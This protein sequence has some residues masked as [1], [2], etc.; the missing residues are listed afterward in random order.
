MNRRHFLKKSL[1]AGAGLAT[2]PS[3]LT[4]YA[5]AAQVRRPAPSSRINLAFI[6]FGTI[7]HLTGPNFLGNPHVQV[8]AI[9]DPITELPNFGYSGELRGGRLVGQRFVNEHY[10]TAQASG[11]FNGCR[12]YEDFREML[13]KED[14]DAVVISTPDHWHCPI[15]LLAAGMGKHIYGQKPLSLTVEEGRR[16]VRAVQES[17]ITW[18]TGSQQRSMG[19]F[20]IACEYVRNGRLG[21]LQRIEVGM[22]GGHYDFSQLADLTKPEA[23]PKEVNFDLWL[24]PAPEREYVPALLQLNWRHNFDFSGGNITDWGAHHMDIVQWALGMDEGGPVAI[25]NI[26]ATTPPPSALYNTTTDF[27]FDVVYANG[28]RA[29][30]TNDRRNGILFEGEGGKSI[31]VS[32]EELTMNPESLRKDKIR[33]DEIHLYESRQHEKNFIDHIFDGK[34]TAAPI[35]AGHRSISIAHLANIAIRLGRSEIK[36][37]PVSESV[38][39][40]AK[41]NAM[42]SRPSRKAYAV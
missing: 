16:M 9:A 13:A 33:E 30:F 34:P 15:T 5:S 26:V 6:G 36:W 7:A 3:I 24:G 23:A 21:K 40:D 35:H 25:E 28:V 1:L 19:Y 17:G 42:L 10:A 22:P 27:N 14:I 4:S 18:Q 39:G 38:P 2:L 41:A 37:D 31:F 29:N 12:V 20:K 8:V 11:S 32:R